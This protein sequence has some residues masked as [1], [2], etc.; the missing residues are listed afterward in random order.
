MT[1]EPCQHPSTDWG[2]EDIGGHKFKITCKLCGHQFI[3]NQRYDT[4]EEEEIEQLQTM[5]D[6]TDN[7][8]NEELIKW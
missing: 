5:S 7:N 1:T 2:S 4:R 6:Q 8:N 3:Y